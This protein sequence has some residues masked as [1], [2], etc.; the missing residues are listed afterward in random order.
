M[1]T[2]AITKRSGKRKMTTDVTE[3]DRVRIDVWDTTVDVLEVRERHDEVHVQ[4]DNGQE[5]WEGL[6]WLNVKGEVIA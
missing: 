3:G 6:T 5:S 4:F 1:L 2:E